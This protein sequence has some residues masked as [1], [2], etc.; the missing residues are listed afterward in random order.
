[1]VSGFS[2]FGPQK[3]APDSLSEFLCAAEILAASGTLK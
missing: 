1:M 3:H 2:L